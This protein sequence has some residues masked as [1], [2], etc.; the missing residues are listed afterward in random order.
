MKVKDLQKQLAEAN[1]EAEIAVCAHLAFYDFTIAI[2]ENEV[3]IT[4]PDLWFPIDPTSDKPFMN[5][6]I[7]P[8]PQA[9]SVQQTGVTWWNMMKEANYQG[10]W[11]GRKTVAKD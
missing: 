9:T 7:F 11:N 10:D 4:A 2:D 8:N 6:T 5:G 1:P 3:W